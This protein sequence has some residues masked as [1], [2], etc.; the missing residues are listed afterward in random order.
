[1]LLNPHVNIKIHSNFLTHENAFELL[2]E[3]D[4]IIDGSDNFQT[5]YI[6]NDCSYY[7]KIPYIYASILQF[8]GY[9]S[10][11]NY[12]SGPCYRC[13]FPEPPLDNAPN[14]QDAGVLGVLPGILG[15]MQA[16][17]ALKII[18]NIG[19]SLSG[20][21]L[22]YHALEMNFSKSKLMK[23]KNCIICEKNR[24]FDNLPHHNLKSCRVEAA[25]VI[26]YLEYKKIMDAENKVQLIDVREVWEYEAEN[27]GGKLIPLN[28]LENRMSEIDRESIIIIRCK[29]GVRSAIAASILKKHG[30]KKIYNLILS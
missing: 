13:L 1:S 5:R 27:I 14:C 12:Q 24:N 23:D 15:S 26:N 28:E 8:I 16:L 30:F 22:Q 10:V 11:F 2:R 17:E 19:E 9:I 20:Y 29:T 21:L 6:I 18:L 7:L 3:H 4:V 25:P